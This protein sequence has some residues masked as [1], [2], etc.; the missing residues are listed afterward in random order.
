MEQGGKKVGDFVVAEPGR[1]LEIVDAELESLA[2]VGE[3][4]AWAGGLGYVRGRLATVVSLWGDDL[5][6]LWGSRVASAGRERD[7][8]S[9]ET[10]GR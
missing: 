5:R 8:D 1:P 2:L 6:G 7:G 4:V 10:D 3:R 9:K